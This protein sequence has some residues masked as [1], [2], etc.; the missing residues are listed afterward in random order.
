MLDIASARIILIDDHDV[1]RRGLQSALV[2][3]GAGEP[4]QCSSYSGAL[5]IARKERFDL[6][7]VD[8]NLGDGDGLLLAATIKEIF[9][10]TIVALLTIESKWSLVERAQRAG[11]S[12]VFSKTTPL[13]SLMDALDQLLSQPERF[14]V[15]SES[16][17]P[18]AL[19]L[20]TQTEREILEQITTGATTEEIARER[21]N[22]IATIKSHLTSIYRKLEVRNRVE[23]IAKLHS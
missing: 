19:D 13:F 22:S 2:A 16:V 14:L 21:H 9:P 17:R 8:R 10:S 11:I 20:L 5:R 6:A 12:A 7:I 3:R 15:I 23:A 18:A 1:V 4:T